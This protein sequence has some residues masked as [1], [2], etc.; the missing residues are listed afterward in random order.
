M[1]FNLDEESVRNIVRGVL[2]QMGAQA[3]DASAAQRPSA[4]AAVSAPN[5]Y[6]ASSSNKGIFTDVKEAAAA[7]F[8]AYKQLC[9]GGMAARQKVVDVVKK[10]TVAN[11]KE[12]GTFEYNET[13]IGRLA[14]KIGK[15]EIVKLV[16]GT[17]WIRPDAYSGDCGIMHEEYCPYGVIGAI[18]PVTHSIPTIAGNIINMVAAGNAIVVNPHP[19]GA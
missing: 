8:E 13:K 4:P 10:M 16:P 18:T 6:T 9:K 17:E 2:R 15:L 11:A 14:D 7:A 1:S 12:W 3:G 19:G 5:I